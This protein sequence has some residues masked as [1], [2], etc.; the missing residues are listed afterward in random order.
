VGLWGRWPSGHQDRGHIMLNEAAIAPLREA[1]I[2]KLRRSWATATLA[3]GAVTVGVTIWVSVRGATRWWLG[4]AVFVFV[5][6]C[7]YLGWAYHARRPIASVQEM[8]SDL[9][10]RGRDQSSRAVSSLVLRLGTFAVAA[11]VWPTSAGSVIWLWAMFASALAI[12]V[13]L[14]WG[15]AWF[16][17]RYL[18]LL[19]VKYILC[20]TRPV[21]R[22]PHNFRR[23]RSGHPRAEHSPR[24]LTL[25]RSPGD[26]C[27]EVPIMG[28]CRKLDP[29]VCAR[30][31]AG[32]R[33]VQS[34]S[35]RCR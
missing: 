30:D 6:C 11:V 31:R 20:H 17:E 29:A 25:D 23:G 5:L 32:S 24:G 34:G 33:A 22:R 13:R 28:A 12:W 9:E 18:D 19:V 8:L 3:C 27:T 10:S 14:T 16:G 15:R 4:V 26:D 35:R 2:A 21:G 1:V 7:F